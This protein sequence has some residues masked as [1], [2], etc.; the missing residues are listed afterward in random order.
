MNLKKIILSL[1]LFTA[2]VEL[3]GVIMIPGF[4]YKALILTIGIKTQEL[5]MLYYYVFRD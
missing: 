2:G 3:A 1:C 5:L 4:L